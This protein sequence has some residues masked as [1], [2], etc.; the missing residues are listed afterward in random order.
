MRDTLN[1]IALAVGEVV[2]RV[3]LPGVAGAMVLG[4]Q[5]AIHDR[6][7]QVDVAR[8][9]IDLRPQGAGALGEFARPHPGEQIE[10]LRYAA[11]AVRA[12]APGRFERAAILAHLV[13]VQ[14]ADVGLALLDELDGVLVER[15]EIVGGEEQTVPPVVAQPADVGHDHVDILLLF[16]DRVGVVETQVA[17]PAK[18]GGD[19][20]ID[21]DG[22]GMADMQV[23]VRLGWKAGDDPAESA[24]SQVLGHG[25]AD[26]VRG[27]GGR[28]FGHGYQRRV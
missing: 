25:R 5:D 19:A 9:H 21:G 22:L 1:R 14:I 10:V 20:E 3:D 23:A 24:G 12:L 17:G 15:L 27:D 16:L 26:E 18:V 13:G 2:E 11:V 28:V 4:V 8:G 6:V 7:A